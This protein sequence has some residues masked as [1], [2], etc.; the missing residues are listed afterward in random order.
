MWSSLR[1]KIKGME[2]VSFTTQ[3]VR[4]VRGSQ[5]AVYHAPGFSPP[6]LWSFPTALAAPV[7]VVPPQA[8][9]SCEGL[10]SLSL[11][12]SLGCKGK[13]PQAEQEPWRW[14]WLERRSCWV[15]CRCAAFLHSQEFPG[16]GDWWEKGEMWLN[17]KSCS[18][19]NEQRGLICSTLLTSSL[20]LVQA[21]APVQR[22]WKMGTAELYALLTLSETTTQGRNKE[23]TLYISMVLDWQ[24]LPKV[25]VEHCNTQHAIHFP[26][27]PAVHVLEVSG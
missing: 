18:S 11:I 27:R 16:N 15:F 25:S 7:P 13:V 3:Q 17:S 1:R 23:K 20:H 26:P 14:A 19:E 5:R 6:L 12:Y 8:R 24:I 21:N 2:N 10:P 9:A 22:G 4:A